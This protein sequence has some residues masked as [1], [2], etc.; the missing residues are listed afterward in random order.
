[1]VNGPTDVLD[2]SA[3]FYKNRPAGP[4]YM[5]PFSFANVN[6]CQGNVSLIQGEEPIDFFVLA[7]DEVKS[8]ED[9]MTKDRSLFLSEDFY[10]YENIN[11]EVLSDS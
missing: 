9:E 1:M 11:G 2:Q 3:M 10:S 8:F 6:F 7:V 4:D 5:P